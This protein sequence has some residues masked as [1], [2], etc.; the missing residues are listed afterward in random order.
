M[1]SPLL[2]TLVAGKATFKLQ[3]PYKLVRSGEDG[4]KPLLIY[5][6]GYGQDV[7]EFEELM[8]PFL[9]L[10]AYHL[11]IQG[12]YPLKLNPKDSKRSGYSYYIYD[13]QD[14]SSYL[15]SIEYTAEF[16][17]EIVDHMLPI[18]KATRISVLGY[19]MGAYLAGYWGCTRWKHTNDIIML[20][21]RLKAELFK[22]KVE[23]QE[24]LRHINIVAFHGK[25]DKIVE[26]S[27]QKAMMD[28]MA[29]HQIKATFHDVEGGHELSTTLT[30]SA[31]K[32]MLD[33]GFRKVNN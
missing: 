27:R 6:H 23:E 5:L 14:D 31:I 11:F 24:V 8:K 16:V 18:I 29:Q 12:P 15:R 21:G 13:E 22:L 4:P 17:Q 28:Y 10:D 1:D 3:V 26:P 9:E 32:W 2:D 7:H 20:N 30:E 19:S 33:L 25:D